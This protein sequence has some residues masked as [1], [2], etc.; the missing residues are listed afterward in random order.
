MGFD[1]TIERISDIERQEASDSDDLTLEILK[2][3]KT[4]NIDQKKLILNLL[5]NMIQ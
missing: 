5:K 2:T 3:V 4:L 1:V